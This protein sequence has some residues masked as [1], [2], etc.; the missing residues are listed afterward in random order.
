MASNHEVDYTI[1][2]TLK[3]NK[4]G[5]FSYGTIQDEKNPHN[6]ELKTKKQKQKQKQKKKEKHLNLKN[7]YS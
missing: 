2:F 7:V 6:S 4:Y 1:G 5:W 3:K